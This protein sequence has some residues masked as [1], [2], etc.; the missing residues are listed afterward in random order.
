MHMA[1][2]KSSSVL[3]LIVSC[4][5]VCIPQPVDHIETKTVLSVSQSL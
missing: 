3:L 2:L 5:S 4:P 1:V